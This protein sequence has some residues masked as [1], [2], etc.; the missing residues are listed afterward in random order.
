[1]NL[2]AHHLPMPQDRRDVLEDAVAED[3]EA[4]EPR[5]KVWA[6]YPETRGRLILHHADKDT[7][8]PML[9]R[10]LS[11]GGIPDPSCK[12][13]REFHTSAHS[14]RASPPGLPQMLEA[15]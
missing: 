13:E 9:M 8:V 2:Q 10:I 11:R 1:M 7:I 12:E 6:P 5:I 15:A 3:W 14:I 4:E